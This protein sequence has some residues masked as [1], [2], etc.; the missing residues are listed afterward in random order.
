MYPAALLM[1]RYMEISMYLN[2]CSAERYME[3]ST[4]VSALHMLR[5]MEISM[6]PGYITH[7]KRYMEI[8][9]HLNFMCSAEKYMEIFKMTRIKIVAELAHERVKYLCRSVFG[10]LSKSAPIFAIFENV[11]VAF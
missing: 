2:M 5:Y 11:L 3:M 1:L 6:Y 10:S 8:S 4:Y 7:A 9:M